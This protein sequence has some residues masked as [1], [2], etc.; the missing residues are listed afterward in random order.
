ML[1][2][3]YFLYIFVALV[4]LVAVELKSPVALRISDF[5]R[6]QQRAENCNKCNK[7]TP[8]QSPD[9]QDRLRRLCC[10][11]TLLHLYFVTPQN[12]KRAEIAPGFTLF[13]ISRY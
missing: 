12:A 11:F 5:Q 9:P 10:T 8:G 7:P 1:L 3:W 4:A 2:F 13:N 6:L